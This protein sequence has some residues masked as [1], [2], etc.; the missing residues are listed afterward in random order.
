MPTDPI[1]AA[2]GD[3]RFVSLATF[4]RSGERVAT[5]A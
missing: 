2:L 1:F 3:G 5:P 4:R